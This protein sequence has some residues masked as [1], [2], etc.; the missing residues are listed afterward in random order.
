MQVFNSHTILQYSENTQ[1]NKK[2]NT[3]VAYEKRNN[4]ANAL[5]DNK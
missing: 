1:A 3:N 5:A 2:T 4:V